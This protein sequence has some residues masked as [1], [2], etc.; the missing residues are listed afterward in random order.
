MKIAFID[1]G[2]ELSSFFSSLTHDHA[3]DMNFVFFSSKPKPISILKKNKVKIYKCKKIRFL[4]DLSFD[5]IKR[6]INPKVFIEYKDDKKLK[7]D[8]LYFYRNLKLFFNDEKPDAVMVW[9][10]SGLASSL[11]CSLAKEVGAI[12][13]YGENGYFPG[14]MQ[15]DNQGVNDN[16]SINKNT[17][18]L[19][20]NFTPNIKQT[21]IFTEI[22]NRYLNDDNTLNQKIEN[23]TKPSFLSRIEDLT[24]RKVKTKN[25]S[26]MPNQLILKNIDEWPINYVFMPLQVHGDSQLIIHSPVYGQDLDNFVKDTA[27]ALNSIDPSL[28][29]IVKLH[30]KDDRCYDQLSQTLSN[31][32][33]VKN[34]S[35]KKLIHFSKVVITINSTV[36]FEALL[37]NKPVV[38]AGSNF[39]IG[40][41]FTFDVNQRSELTNQLRL[42]LSSDEAPLG[43]QNFCHFIYQEYLTHGN[44]KNFSEESKLAVSKKLRLIANQKDHLS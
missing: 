19:L 7:V 35:A 33:F 11:A 15:L 5:D 23:P 14:T 4:Q 17:E 20:N 2:N 32:I 18:E 16:A 8:A 12:C 22:L 30:P 43:T 38:T 25:K 21:E 40:H 37:F 3:K 26:I 42:A 31:A 34:I 27:S 10:G 13:I 24:R 28:K 9:N 39:Y 29:L 41:G 44:P 6:N 36:G 1:L